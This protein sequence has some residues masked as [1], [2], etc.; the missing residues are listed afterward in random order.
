[1]KNDRTIHVVTEG[2]K[3]VFG[4]G[5]GPQVSEVV[6][7]SPSTDPDAA[8]VL[9]QCLCLDWLKLDGHARIAGGFARGA[10]AIWDLTTA[11][12]LLTMLA[13]NGE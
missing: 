5:H 6:T 3:V 1:L 11:S 7:L 10:V 12:P 9:G 8:G 13:E 4:N 2:L